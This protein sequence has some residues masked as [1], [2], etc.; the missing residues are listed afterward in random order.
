M[1][2]PT[3]DRNNNTVY[4]LVEFRRSKQNVLNLILPDKRFCLIMNCIWSNIRGRGAMFLLEDE[5]S[6]ELHLSFLSSIAYWF[7]LKPNPASSKELIPEY[8]EYTAARRY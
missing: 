7:D 6:T 4:I 2:F 1:I 8:P 3:G 5:I